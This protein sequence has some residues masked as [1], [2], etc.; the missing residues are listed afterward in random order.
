MIILGF[1]ELVKMRKSIR[2]Y[3]PDS[4][5][6]E[7]LK[8]VIEA[9]RLAP[10]WKNSQPWR[11][12]VV[13][14]EEIKKKI[15]TRDWAAEAP[16]IIVGV[17]DPTIS[18]TRENKQYYLVDMGI[19]MEHMMLA[20]TELGLGTCW[21]VSTNWSGISSAIELEENSELEPISLIA[22]GYPTEDSL[23]QRNRKPIQDIAFRD[24]ITKKWKS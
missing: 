17:A 3:K 16:I 7:K 8:Y 13:T 2:K 20:A 21:I 15:T 11:F 6:E 23:P 5:P 22:L 19:A 4:I 10:S 14:K 12:I 18:G 9:A 24:T 1:I